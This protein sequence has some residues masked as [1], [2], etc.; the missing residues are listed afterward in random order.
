MSVTITTSAADRF[1]CA[2]VDNLAKREGLAGVDIISA[3][4]PDAR[5]ETIQFVE[6]EFEQEW[7]SIGNLR[8]EEKFTWHGFVACVKPGGGE[9]V[10]RATRARVFALFAELEAELRRDPRVGDASDV[11]TANRAAQIMEGSLV[12]RAVP[13]ADRACQLTFSVKAQGTLPTT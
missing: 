2:L 5:N 3:F 11:K 8:R 4:N 12:Q 1:V 13:D 7:G 6:C 9:D 10:I